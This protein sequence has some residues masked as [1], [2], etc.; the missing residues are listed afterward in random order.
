[1]T[2]AQ[3]AWLALELVATL[4]SSLACTRLGARPPV[5]A[6]PTPA[7]SPAVVVQ[8]PTP[9]TRPAAT[10]MPPT[11]IALATPTSQPQ[12]TPTSLPLATATP[13]ASKAEPGLTLSSDAGNDLLF[14]V[15]ADDGSRIYYYGTEADGTMHLTHIAADDGAGDHDIILFDERL[16]PIQWVLS[17][18][19]VAVYPSPDDGAWFDP[20]KAFHVTLTDE[21]EAT[22][23]I[24][25]RPG[26]LAELLGE[27]EA[28]AGRHFSGARGFLDR[29]PLS[30]EQ[31]V[32]RA[33]QG[34]PDQPFYIAAAAG[35]STTAAALRLDA[36]SR[37]AAAGRVRG[38][39]APQKVIFGEL[40]KVGAGALAGVLAGVVPADLDPGDGPAVRV[41]LCRGAAK[42]G[43]CHYMFYRLDRLGACIRNCRTSLRCFTDICMPMDI[44]AEAAM[45]L[46]A[47]MAGR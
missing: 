13:T 29:H 36:A 31:L 22:F 5:Q 1:M 2:I 30:F 46:S 41:L 28:A 47:A 11:T 43:M 16:L 20:Q 21:A 18:M 12:G 33:H 6:T 27:M 3:R 37:T 4:A 26:D 14:Y 9:T 32:E 44:S 42:Y 23:T 34:G 38:L 45:R 39:A 8:P 25:M 10:T 17:T 35:F 40:V 15:T 24:D 19:T 7:P